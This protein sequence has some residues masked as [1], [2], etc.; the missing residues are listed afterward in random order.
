MSWDGRTF[1]T[2]DGDAGSRYIRQTVEGDM[3]TPDMYSVTITGRD[4]C[5]SWGALYRQRFEGLDTVRASHTGLSVEKALFR[6]VGSSSNWALSPLDS[7]GTLR[8]GDRVVVRLTVRADRDYSYVT[9]KD[10]RA[11]CFEPSEQVSTVGYDG[12]LDYYRSSKDA[13]TNYYFHTLPKGTYVLEHHL[14][15]TMQGRYSS[16]IATLQS[17]YAPEYASHTS[18]RT[19]VVGR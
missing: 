9:L 8:L 12:R 14:Y 2:E 16:G 3:V 17:L 13:S 11:P 18:G 15:T 7:I 4:G 1:G 6:A 5:P 19:I 10:M